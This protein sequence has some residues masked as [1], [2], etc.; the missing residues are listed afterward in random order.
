MSS[1]IPDFLNNRIPLII[2]KI[3]D[4]YPSESLDRGL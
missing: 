3:K 2:E 1:S 4:Y